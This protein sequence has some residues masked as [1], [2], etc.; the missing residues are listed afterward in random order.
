MDKVESAKLYGLL[1][2]AMKKHGDISKAAL[3]GKGI[4]RHLFAL[5]KIAERGGSGL[6][7]IFN[8]SGYVVPPL[9]PVFFVSYF[10][11]Y[12]IFRIQNTPKTPSICPAT[13]P[14]LWS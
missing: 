3:M 11:F 8:D 13:N 5:R 1:D 10:I 2:K 7:D 14:I 6:P 4:D 12:I 9:G